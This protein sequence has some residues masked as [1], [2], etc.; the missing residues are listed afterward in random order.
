MVLNRFIGE[1]FFR[2]SGFVLLDMVRL[3]FPNEHF[4]EE[5]NEG[6]PECVSLDPLLGEPVVWYYVLFEPPPGE[7]LERN[8]LPG[9]GTVDCLPPR[10]TLAQKQFIGTRALSCVLRASSPVS[11]LIELEV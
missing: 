3:D 7:F 1:P 10:P 5:R 8:A 6:A 2:L 4:P 9:R 11:S